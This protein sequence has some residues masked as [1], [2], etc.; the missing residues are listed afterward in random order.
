MLTEK[1]QTESCK[2]CDQWS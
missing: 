2:T 1:N